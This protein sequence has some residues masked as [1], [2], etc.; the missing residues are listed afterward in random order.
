M[1]KVQTDFY[2]RECGHQEYLEHNEYECPK[3][4]STN[5]FNGSVITC[6]C[7]EMIPGGSYTN[8]CPECGRMYNAF[9]QELA[10]VDEWDPDDAYDTFGPQHEEDW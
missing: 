6:K 1:V 2:C 3:C 7:G 5:V 8:E 4:G 10:P 9:G